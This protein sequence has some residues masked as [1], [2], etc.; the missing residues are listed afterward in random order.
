MLVEGRASEPM[1]G[2]QVA[3]DEAAG[4]H[5]DI[6]TDESTAE[7]GTHPGGPSTRK[8]REAEGQRQYPFWRDPRTREPS[9]RE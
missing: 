2:E 6:D 7:S 1:I 5:E 3:H 4:D 9:R 8:R